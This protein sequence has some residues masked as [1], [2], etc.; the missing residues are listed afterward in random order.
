MVST[1][2]V[3]WRA[4]KPCIMRSS[5]TGR[6]SDPRRRMSKLDHGR[7]VLRLI[8]GTRRL[9]ASAVAAFKQVP[10]LGIAGP[11]SPTPP[12]Q[13]S[14]ALHAQAMAALQHVAKH[15][16]VRRVRSLVEAVG[17]GRLKIALLKWFCANGPLRICESTG[18][19]LYDK[20][21]RVRLYE[22]MT[23]PYWKYTTRKL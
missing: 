13:G 9:E 14:A 10:G 17:D 1:Q 2:A 8:D 16:D 21:A 12:C 18:S 3:L 6:V 7:P 15:K 11:S 23:T 5:P 4:K 22:A 19:I 20:K